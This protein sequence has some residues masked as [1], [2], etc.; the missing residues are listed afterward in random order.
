MLNV[1]ALVIGS[2]AA[3]LPH[4][5]FGDRLSFFADFML[6]SIVFSLTPPEQRERFR[7]TGIRVGQY[8]YFIRCRRW[9]AEGGRG[10][11][12]QH[13][14]QTSAAEPLGEWRGRGKRCGASCGHRRVGGVGGNGGQW[15]CRWHVASWFIR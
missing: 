5:L 11:C 14:Q 2:L 3:Y 6:G 4:L 8:G 15:R 1:I 9:A 12:P 7:K 10:R 13:S